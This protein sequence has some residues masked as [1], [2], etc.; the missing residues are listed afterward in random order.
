MFE[1]FLI[2]MIFLS[3]FL[4]LV[5]IKNYFTYKTTTKEKSLLL[6]DKNQ[7]NTVVMLQ[8]KLDVLVERVIVL[9]ELAINKNIDLSQ[10]I[11]QL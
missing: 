1:L 4:L 8:R 6:Q 2:I 3:P 10:K 7:K 11:A 9:E 5:L